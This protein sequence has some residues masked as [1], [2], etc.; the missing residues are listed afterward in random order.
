MTGILIQTLQFFA[1]LSMLVLI[2]EFG[3]FITARM[4][5]IRVDKFYIFFNPWFSLFKRKVGNTEYGI[6]WIPLG[7][8]VGLY[9]NREVLIDRETEITKQREEAEDKLKRLKKG[10]QS[11]VIA[12]VE[13]EIKGY[14]EAIKEVQEQ[15]RTLEPT[16]DELRGKPAWQRLIVMVA[17]VVMNVLFAIA[18]YSGM[19]FTWGETYYHNDDMVNG[20]LFNEEAEAL[21]FQDGDRILTID[22]ESI[23]NIGEISERLLIV[24]HD[25][26]AK[27]ARDGEE[28]T[29]TLP[30]NDLVAMR[31]RGGFRNF[32][33]EFV[34]FVIQSVERQSAEQAG[35]MAG[36]KVVA[37]NDVAI[38][39][40]ISATPLL[41]EAKGSD[42]V[43]TVERN[44]E[45]VALTLPV[46][47]NG[48]IGVTIA[49]VAPRQIEYGFFESIPQGFKHTGQEISSYWNQLVMM[50]KPETK[51][52]KEMGGFISIGSVFPDSWN[53]YSFWNITALLSVILAVMNLLPI[54]VLDGGHVLFTLWELITGH[55]P[56][57]KFMT[58]AQ[59]IGFY[60]L[61]A[62]LI[63]AN[64]SD[65]LRLFN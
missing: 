65:I 22:G 37:I 40:F 52:Y 15:F 16:K 47:E 57:E 44:Q 45:L 58:V 26:E 23:G 30:L 46:D 10:G 3:H 59:N 56:S 61:I 33:G 55:K 60:L 34:P 21:G 51:L 64:G 20:Y 54:P 62:L 48:K 29:F 35:L 42:V 4:F 5:G 38:T 36:D 12:E 8:Y 9:D 32:I 28:V 6:G 27:V 1:S 25:L 11:E 18:I 14:D 49:T 39:D 7:G 50:F 53:W 13:A 43:L 63:Y 19:M 2:H 24:D 31:E 17:G 41:S